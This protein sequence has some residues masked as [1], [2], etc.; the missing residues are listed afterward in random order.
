MDFHIRRYAAVGST[1][2]LARSL[3]ASGE[4]S[5][6]IVLA[7]RQTA[8]RGRIEGRSWR[9][10]TGTSL[11]M[12]LC[13]K[14]DFLSVKAPPLRIGLAVYDVLSKLA[15]SC[16]RVKWPNDIVGLGG[17]GDMEKPGFRKLCGL[18]CETTG[19]WFLA[20][21]GVNLRRGSYP[22]TLKDKATSL[23]EIASAMAGP[24]PSEIPDTDALALA[25]SE[26]AAIRLEDEGWRKEYEKAMWG[27]GEEIDFIVG[28]PER[29]DLKRGKIVG[30]DGMGRLLLAAERGDIE[31]FWSGEI[32][33]L[34]KAEP[35]KGIEAL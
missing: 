1:M 14:G 3:I 16:L 2:D 9:N 11:L 10:G 29:G 35:E 33:S 7:D 31:A 17:A 24:N 5:G 18:L 15:L 25:I 21:I 12:T 26:A 20:G 4:D 6:L 28:H 27:M 19:G 13:L 30:I 34:R 32:S 22:D 23:D 8:G